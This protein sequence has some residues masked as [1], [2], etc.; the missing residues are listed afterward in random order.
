MLFEASP[1]PMWV[2][3]AE[4]LAFLAVNDAAVRHYGYSREEFLAM[5]ITR[6]P[7]RPRTSPALLADVRPAAAR[8]RPI[9][10]HLAPPP[11]GR[12]R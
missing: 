1:L 12:H 9:A 10:E 6:H 4:T 3:D 7:A 11:Q 2:Y 5:T 8:A